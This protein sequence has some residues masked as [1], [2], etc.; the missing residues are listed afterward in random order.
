M[1]TINQFGTNNSGQRVLLG[2]MMCNGNESQLLDCQRDEMLGC[3]RLEA[4][5][6]ICLG[7]N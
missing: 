2:N 1:T 7:K 5:G 3:G 6:V 4:A